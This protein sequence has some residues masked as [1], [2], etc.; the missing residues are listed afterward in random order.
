MRTIFYFILLFLPLC[1]FAQSKTQLRY[2]IN[3]KRIGVSYTSEEALLR[4]REFKRLDST[5][6]IGWMYEGTYRFER[7]ADYLGFKLAAEQLQKSLDL[8]YKDF[9]LEISNRTSDLN[10]YYKHYQLRRDYDYI[11]YTLMNAYSNMERPDLVWNLLQFCKKINLQ[12]E[13]YS[14]TY[15]Y[16]AWTVH[17]NRFYTASKYAFLKNSIE[18]NELYAETLLDS[19]EW[20]L[21]QDAKLNDPLFGINY[22]DYTIHSVWHYKSILY[23]YQL[24]IQKAKKYYDNLQG[25]F[26]FPQN[27]YATFLAIQGKFREAFKYYDLAKAEDPGD[28]RM[29]ESFY[30]SSILNVY[31]GQPKEGIREMK[32]II[33][34]N[35]TTPGYG[36]YNIGLARDLSYDGQI[37]AAKKYITKAEQFKEIHRGTTLGQSH[38]DFT[39]AVTQLIIKEKEIASIKF[40]NKNW[41]ISPRD[42]FTI[43]QLSAEK[44][45]L[46]F[47]IINQLANNPE[48]ELVVYKLFSTE[49]TVSFDEIWYLVKDFSTNFFI[50]KYKLFAEQDE[51]PLI[52]NYYNY[53]VGNLYIENDEYKTALQYLNNVLENK[54]MDS[55]F[56]LL[57]RARLYLAKATSYR[58]LNDYNQANINAIKAYEIYP[59]LLPFTRNKLKMHLTTNAKTKNENKIIDELKKRN[60]NWVHI[61]DSNSVEVNIHFG[62]LEGYPTISYNT[63]LNGKEIVKQ[64]TFTYTNLSEVAKDLSFYIFNI[65]DENLNFNM[66]EK[67]DKGY[68]VSGSHILNNLLTK[69]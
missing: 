40:L 2:E 14:D 61:P 54:E 21:K 29:K 42:I 12:D 44:Y 30:Y 22:F 69:K 38:Y 4:S 63:S 15:N 51:R 26:Y 39:V 8:L 59:Q 57:F 23:S 24:E 1:V 60:I 32:D 9:K 48:R 62:T 64:N 50:K 49:N 36:W 65:G 11:A 41:W 43:T 68:S 18:E 16:L 6:Y 55:D 56:E 46:Q 28:K 67:S 20:K 13:V 5:Y 45:G 10:T 47:L 66:M 25:T 35:G 27:N 34:T 19:A 58:N 31:K 53:F 52:R 7:A 33:S 17:R 3:A 37:D